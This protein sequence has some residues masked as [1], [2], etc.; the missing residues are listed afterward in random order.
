MVSC[1]VN[2]TCATRFTGVR[3]NRFSDVSRHGHQWEQVQHAPPASVIRK[4]DKS[5]VNKFPRSRERGYRHVW[6]V[7]VALDLCYRFFSSF[8]F[9]FPSSRLTLS[10]IRTDESPRDMMKVS[11]SSDFFSR[12][13]VC[14]AVLSVVSQPFKKQKPTTNLQRIPFFF[15]V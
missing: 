1:P 12:V 15:S 5:P 9:T 6:L 2:Q 7:S 4:T 10:R 14:A 3:T 11:T 8:P 13:T